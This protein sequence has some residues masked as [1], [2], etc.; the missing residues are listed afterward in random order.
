MNEN[1]LSPCRTCG[2]LIS[3]NLGTR[4]SSSGL[5][6]GTTFDTHTSGSCPHCGEAEPHLTDEDIEKRK[7]W[8]EDYDKILEKAQK[9]NRMFGWF[10]FVVFFV[11]VLF[12]MIMVFSPGSYRRNEDGII[13]RDGKPTTYPNPNRSR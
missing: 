11:V 1:L 9:S 4:G 3:S 7:Q 12:L 5:T 8:E 13:T 2:E 10:L 6:D